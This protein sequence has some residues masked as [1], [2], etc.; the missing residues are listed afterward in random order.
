MGNICCI[1]DCLRSRRHNRQ[2]TYIPPE[3]ETTPPPLETPPYRFRFPAATPDTKPNPNHSYQY[4]G[5]YHSP[6][7]DPP[8]INQL[9]YPWIAGERF[10][11]I[12]PPYIEHQKAVTIHNDVNLKKE[13][14]RLEPDPVNPGR[15]LV[16]FKFDSGVS[17]RITIVFFAKECE[18]CNLIATKEHTLPSITFEFNKGLGQKFIQPSGTGIDLSVFEDSELFGKVGRGVYPLAVKAEAAPVVGSEGG[19]MRSMNV[20]A[21]ITQVVYVKEN[22]EI[23]IRAVK[24]ILWVN[25]FRYELQDIYGMGNSTVDGCDED[26]SDTG[27]ECVICMSEPRDTT[28]LPCRHMV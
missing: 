18:E 2:W 16:S 23:Q 10:P 9:P 15:Y 5:H 27:K 4:P 28:V 25:G 3:T 8:H 22:G 24:Q 19:K 21:Q 12:P 26:P 20:N 7:S 11:M 17:G 14:L 13:T 6:P 1:I